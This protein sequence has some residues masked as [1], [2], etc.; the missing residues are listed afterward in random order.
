[1]V[2]T[3]PGVA[4]TYQG[5]E[6]V[7]E[8]T[9]VSWNDTQDPWACNSDPEHYYEISRDPSRTPFPWDD[10][11]NG[12][13]SKANSTWL[14]I[15]EN[16]RTANVKVQEEATNSHLKIFKLL[17][18]L[19]KRTVMKSGSYSGTLS[20]NKNVYVYRRQTNDDLVIVVL[21]F[22]KTEETVDI[23]SL[24]SNIPSHMVVYTSSLNSG[25]ERG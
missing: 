24:F 5:E 19:R 15:A 7:L 9:K 4:I 8:D 3:L 20:N 14:P 22:G 17:T 23:S 1:L 12:G 10:S 6:L 11:K 16:Y 25:L 21:N 2:Q 13:F 18:K